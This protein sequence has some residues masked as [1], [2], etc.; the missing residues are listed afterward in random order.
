MA[1][2]L[3]QQLIGKEIDGIWHTAVVIFGKE[4]YYG[5]GKSPIIDEV[6]TTMHGQP[7]RIIDMGE[8]AIPEAV[9][10]EYIESL[11]G[12]WTA[13]RY[14]LFQNNCNNFSTWVEV[15]QFLLGKGIPEYILNLPNE[16]L[17]TPFGQQVAPMISEMFS[18]ARIA[19][20]HQPDLD[21]TSIMNANPAVAGAVMNALAGGA[22]GAG[23]APPSAPTA[24]PAP[25]VNGTHP[26]TNG[27]VENMGMTSV[28]PTPTILQTQR[29]PIL[30]AQCSQMD[31]ILAKLKGLLEQHGV[32][33]DVKALEG[34]VDAL[35][36]KFE[37]KEAGAL[38]LPTGWEA[39]IVG[40]VNG[41]PET[42]IFPALDILR[43]L[44]LDNAASTHF[45]RDKNATIARLL[46]R[47]GG[48]NKQF[49]QLPMATRLMSLRLACNLFATD[50]SLAHYLSSKPVDADPGHGA[51]VDASA[52]SL[53]T[54][55]H[56]SVLTALLVESLLCGEDGVRQ[57][58][59]SLAFNMAAKSLVIRAVA[60]EDALLEEWESE[61]VAAVVKAVETEQEHEILLRLLSA[62]GLILFQRSE[63]VIAL[64]EVLETPT[65][66]QTK[67][68]T[69]KSSASEL[70]TSEEKTRLEKLLALA[71]EIV[72]L[73]Q[74]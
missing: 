71:S 15:C 47:L 20:E 22:G 36:R 12:H 3:S 55:T 66:L 24:T 28:T 61:L 42:D 46:Y 74:Q 52:A 40:I 41:L 58:A 57:V 16:F 18:P 59:A 60:A 4:V 48:G 13:E 2:M 7:V 31:K 68:A 33:Y 1:R 67:S 49:S 50:P 8:T 39:T 29:S 62:L 26:A 37:A 21:L 19:A 17:S 64:A 72:T 9:F 43:L 5:Q 27:A 73:I 54:V 23:M 45:V 30:F 63:S 56:R 34:I 70:K 25:A 14:N 10:W 32:G 53:A 6:G 51:T 38:K 69:L 35:K 65:I 44:I 11:R